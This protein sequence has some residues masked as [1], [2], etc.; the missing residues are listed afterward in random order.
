MSG[1]SPPSGAPT[2]NVAW[3]AELPGV[4][5]STPVIWDNRVF[6]SGADA[7]K[8]TLQAMCFDRRRGKLLWTH[9]AAKGIRRDNRSN[10][11]SSSPVTDGR[12]AIFFYGNGE[13]E[14]FDPDGGR[15]WARNIQQDYGPFAFLWTFSSSPLLYD[16]KLYLQVLQRNVP[17]EGSRAGRSREPVVSIGPR[18]GDGQDHLADHPPQRGPRRIAGIVYHTDPLR[19]ASGGRC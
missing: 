7:D 1:T 14:C 3:I 18:S 19:L 2:E 8:D 13:L 9:D 6:L 17:V 4:A 16:G 5:A 12:R 15:R 10:Y 11:A